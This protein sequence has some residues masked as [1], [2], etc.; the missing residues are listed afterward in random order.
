MHHLLRV[1]VT[2]RIGH[3]RFEPKPGFHRQNMWTSRRKWVID[4]DLIGQN[5]DF[6]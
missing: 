4:M 2:H 1:H 5:G 6:I 3:L